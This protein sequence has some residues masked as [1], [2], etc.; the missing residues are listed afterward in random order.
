MVCVPA[1][2]LAKL[3]EKALKENGLEEP[4]DGTP[5]RVAVQQAYQW[6][7]VLK[8]L[9]P[10][11]KPFLCN[12][13]GFL[14]TLMP[15]S[16]VLKKPLGH[17]ASAIRRSITEQ[18][19][20]EQVEAYSSLVRQDPRAKAPPFFGRSSM[21]LLMFSNWQKANVYGFDLSGA[22]VQPRETPLFPCYVQ[23]IQGPYDFTDGII[24]VGK[25]EH[26]NIWLS[27]HKVKG[28][29]SVMER[30]MREDISGE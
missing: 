23:T 8:D 6:R 12:C 14:V 19:T 10:S 15:V 9:L 5:S 22:A 3:K 25:D 2:F 21:Q 18:G 4:D 11:E 24:I 20:R 17:L 30:K 27:G 7:S 16:D 29:W 26:E 13:V 1:E 28:E